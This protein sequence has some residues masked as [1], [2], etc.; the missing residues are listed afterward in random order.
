MSQEIRTEPRDRGDLEEEEVERIWQ[1]FK[2][3]EKR[4]KESAE[5]EPEKVEKE[6]AEAE[7]EF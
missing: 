1:Q 2:A 4:Q 6:E 3:G 7:W 5:L